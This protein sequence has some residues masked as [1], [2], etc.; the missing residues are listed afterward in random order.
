M[1][2]LLGWIL[3]NA[4]LN[5]GLLSRRHILEQEHNQFLLRDQNIKQVKAETDVGNQ[6]SGNGVDS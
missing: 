5:S 6:F 1:I 4:D 3:K 2:I